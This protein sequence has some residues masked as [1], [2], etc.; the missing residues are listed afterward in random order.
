VR[1]FN[2][3]PVKQLHLAIFVTPGR[4]EHD[5]A[6][7]DKQGGP[8]TEINVLVNTAISKIARLDRPGVW[9]G[10][11]YFGVSELFEDV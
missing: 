3:L 10:D 5:R 2:A 9:R 11:A 8:I 7:R 6:C 4:E 1:C